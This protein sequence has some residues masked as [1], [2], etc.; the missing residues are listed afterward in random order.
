MSGTRIVL[1]RFENT[2]VPKSYTYEFLIRTATTMDRWKD[3]E[4]EMNHHFKQLFILYQNCLKKKSSSGLSSLDL[5]K[6]EENKKE[7]V[8]CSLKPFLL[9]K[10]VSF[11]IYGWGG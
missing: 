6:V 9:T 4:L 8:E 5:I 10:T 7:I 1:K 2:Y 3:Y 11:Q